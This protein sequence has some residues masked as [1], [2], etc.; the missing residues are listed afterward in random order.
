MM[1]VLMNVRALSIHVCMKEKYDLNAR[2]SVHLQ[3]GGG[4]TVTRGNPRDGRRRS[5]CWCGENVQQHV[6]IYLCIFASL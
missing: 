4:E 2:F 5:S 1:M 3:E 6:H